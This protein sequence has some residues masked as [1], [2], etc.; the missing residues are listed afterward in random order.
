MNC[1]SYTH[2]CELTFDPPYTNIYTYK[3]ME[4]KMLFDR[5]K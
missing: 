2:N 5:K 4:K 3:I 1:V